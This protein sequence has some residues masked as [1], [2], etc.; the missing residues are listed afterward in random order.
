[1]YSLVEAGFGHQVIVGTDGA[2][3]DLWASLGGA[4]GLSWLASEFPVLLKAAG[5]DDEAIQDVMRNNAVS[6]LSW[7]A[8]A[9]DQ[10]ENFAEEIR[11]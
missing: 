5:L 6:A 3:R 7:R 2:R 4:P 1:V 8:P 11:R 10:V 9:A